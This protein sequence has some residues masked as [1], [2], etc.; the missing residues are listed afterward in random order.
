M[1]TDSTFFPSDPKK[2]RETIRRYERA[3]KKLHYDDGAGKRF[4]IGPLYLLM[5]D[6]AG[7]LRSYDWYKKTFPDDVP[8]AF[9][10]LCWVLTLLKSEK[11][12]EAKSKLRELIFENLYIVPVLLGDNPKQYPFRH[13]SNWRELSYVLEG[14]VK[15]IFSLWSDSERIW[16]KKEWQTPEIARDISR[17]IDLNYI[18]DTQNGYDERRKTLKQITKIARGEVDGFADEK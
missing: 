11:P 1:T 16:L 7:A 9:N 18:L 5:A 2:I 14:P 10:H 15:E 8:E 13:G 17:F 6:V 4:L 3:F 12:V